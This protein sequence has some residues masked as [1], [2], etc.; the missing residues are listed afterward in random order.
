M[1]LSPP[2]TTPHTFSATEVACPAWSGAPLPCVTEVMQRIEDPPSAFP[3]YFRPAPKYRVPACLPFRGPPPTRA[4]PKRGHRARHTAGGRGTFLEVRL[5]SAKTTQVIVALAYL[6]SAIRSQGFSP[7]Q[8][9]DPTRASWLCFTPHPPIGF[10]SP[11]LFPLSQPL[12]LSAIVALLPLVNLCRGSKPSRLR[13][14][15][16]SASSCLSTRQDQIL[17]YARTTLNNDCDINR[18]SV[19]PKSFRKNGEWPKPPNRAL[20]A[21][22]PKKQDSVL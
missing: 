18:S 16:Q 17:R 11:K 4:M 2:S 22:R 15:V 9:F 5:L 10:W 6:T 1:S 21:E 13:P 20:Y 12:R 19:G 14:L 8:R 3:T 7:S